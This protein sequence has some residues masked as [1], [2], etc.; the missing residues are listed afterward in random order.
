VLASSGPA[1]LSDWL[2][3]SAVGV[4]ML[5]AML[6]AVE[7]V[8]GRKRAVVAVGADAVLDEPVT[9]PLPRRLGRMGVAV[10]VLGALLHAMSVVLRGVAT[11]RIPWANMYEYLSAVGLVAVCAWLCSGSSRSPSPSSPA[12]SGPSRPGGGTGAGIR[13]RRSRSS[14][15]SVTPPTCTPERPRGGGPGAR[16]GLVVAGLHSYS[17]F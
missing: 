16:R 12:R 6:S 1:V 17:G 8:V 15:G 3:T 9:V 7:Y 2:F 10:T 5:A 11:E 4:Y 13:R 14:P